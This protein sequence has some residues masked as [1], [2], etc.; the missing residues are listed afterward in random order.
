MKKIILAVLLSAAVDAVP[1]FAQEKKDMPMKEEGMEADGMLMED[2]KE[3][4]GTMMKM[5]NRMGGMMQ[6]QGMMKNQDIK[7]M[8]STV[9]EMSDMMSD[10]GQMM[11]S[12]EM[13]PKEMSEMSKMMND[14]SAMLKQM[15][16]RMG[17][18]TKKTK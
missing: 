1:A 16:E 14:L 11:E 9:D 3:M 6:G 2:I 13:T 15:S 10:M 7:G 17:R 5:K 4:Q 8:G 12:G 18:G